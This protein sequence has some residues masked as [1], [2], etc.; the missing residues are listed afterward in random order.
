MENYY[1]ISF[2]KSF[3][4]QK[5]DVIPNWI[6]NPVTLSFMDS[7]F[8]ENDNWER[9]NDIR[10]VKWKEIECNITHGKQYNFYHYKFPLK[11]LC[12]RLLLQLS[13]YIGNTSGIHQA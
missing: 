11:L 6:G 12:V 2:R 3:K 4:K 8:R 9:G 13:R 7:R 5:R 10:A 1:S